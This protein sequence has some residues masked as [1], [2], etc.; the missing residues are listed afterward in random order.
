MGNTEYLHKYLRQLGQKPLA[1]LGNRIVV[2]MAV[3]SD[4]A[5]GHRVI[6]AAL[7]LPT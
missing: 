5:E 2:G 4:V 1:E 7:Q 3:G 6:R